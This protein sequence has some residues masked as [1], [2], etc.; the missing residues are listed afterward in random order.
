MNRYTIEN[1]RLFDG[2]K[3]APNLCTVCVSNGVISY[4]GDHPPPSRTS[5]N[6][7]IIRGEGCM[8]LPG[9]IDS[10][11]HVFCAIDGLKQCIPMGVTTVLDMHNEPDNVKYMKELCRAS[12]NL[13]DVLSAYYAATIKDGWPRAIVKHHAPNPEVSSPY[14]RLYIQPQES[15]LWLLVGKADSS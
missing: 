6:A 9:L 14:F 15:F 7:T 5:S 8:L 2:E 13:P 4:V 3:T 12:R 11:T 1:V 10:H